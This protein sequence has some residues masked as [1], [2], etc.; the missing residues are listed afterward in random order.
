MRIH[1]RLCC[2]AVRTFLTALTIVTVS[3]GP[4]R[5]DA[6]RLTA[7]GDSI[8]QGYG[9][10]QGDG[11]VPQL[12]AW[13]Q[14]RGH[15]VQ[16]LNAG[17]SG[18]TSAGGAARVDWTLADHPNGLIVLFGGNDLL[19]GLAPEQM[20]ENL[21]KII[22]GAEAQDIPVFLIGLEAPTTYGTSYKTEF[23]GIFTKV[24]MEHDLMLYGDIFTA[25]KAT[26]LSKNDTTVSVMQRDNIHP[27]QR[28][29]ELIVADLGPKV[30][31]FLRR[32]TAH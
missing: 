18:E 32:L 11:V 2:G 10:A 6:V 29:V 21:S 28:G 12:E 14:A 15:D 1:N 4:V 22:I 13:L 30:E 16:I 7:M 9:L 3:L 31:D 17:V 24:A 19:R 27:N 8:I 5:A 20:Y 23:D 26:A 25:I